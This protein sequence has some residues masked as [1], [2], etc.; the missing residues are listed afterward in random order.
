[1]ATITRTDVALCYFTVPSTG[2][3]ELIPLNDQANTAMDNFYDDES[4]SDTVSLS[5]QD[6]GRGGL[7]VSDGAYDTLKITC[8]TA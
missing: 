2:V 6:A 5:Q 3:I 7:A 1:M 8:T 4:D